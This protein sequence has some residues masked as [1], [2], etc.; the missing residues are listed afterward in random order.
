M[1]QLVQALR[2]EPSQ[3]DLL[4]SVE[5]DLLV[6]TQNENASGTSTIVATSSNSVHPR[7]ASSRQSTNS[8]IPLDYFEG[9]ES[10]DLA[11]FLIKIACQNSPI[12]I[13]LYWY[14]KVE[15][16]ANFG[17]KQISE[18]YSS[19]ILKLQ[20]ALSSGNSACKQTLATI[21][22]QKVY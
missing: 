14:L 10:M 12:A 4:A 16:E 2:Y 7:M 11:T 1:P 17:N 18:F 20:Q 6:V 13:F 19:V 15:V 22:S 3:Q 8:D 21:S 5:E 9:H